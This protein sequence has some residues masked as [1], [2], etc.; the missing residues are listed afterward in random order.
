MVVLWLT[1]QSTSDLRITDKKNLLT[2]K[3]KH[4]IEYIRGFNSV[5][6]THKQSRSRADICTAV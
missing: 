3:K 6:N 5:P 2:N 4:H 1:R